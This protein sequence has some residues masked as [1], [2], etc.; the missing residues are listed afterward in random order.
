MTSVPFLQGGREGREG[1]KDLFP[2]L[3]E[4]FS[5]ASFGPPAGRGR[6]CHL[7]GLVCATMPADRP[8]RVMQSL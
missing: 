5:Q 1:R 6:A 8:G 2:H 7:L 3:H 4:P